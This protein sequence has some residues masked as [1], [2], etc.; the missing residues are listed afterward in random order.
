MRPILSAVLLALTLTACSHKQEISGPERHYTLT[1]K[2]IA[3][4]TAHQTATIDAAAI[5]DFMEAMTMDY[6]IRSR[7]EFNRLHVG[8][9]IKGTVNVSATGE[10][11]NLSGIQTQNAGR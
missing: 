2:V 1:G 6:P 9:K 4:D 10:Q 11:Y 3:I 8:D 5:P 7:D